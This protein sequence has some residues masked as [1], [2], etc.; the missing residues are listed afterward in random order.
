MFKILKTADASVLK[1]ESDVML[2]KG[3]FEFSKETNDASAPL[4]S[5]LLQLP[6]ITK[7]FISANFIALQK[8][9]AIDWID[10]QEEL[11][12]VIDNY[13][14]QNNGLFNSQKKA[15]VEVYAESTPNPDVMKFVTNKLILKDGDVEFKNA[16]QAKNHPFI[17]SLFGLNFVKSIFVEQY[18]ISLTKDPQTDWQDIIHEIRAHI[19]LNLKPIT[20][21]KTEAVSK[22]VNPEYL[23]AIS[24][25]IIAILDEYIK[26]AVMADG[27]NII[28]ESYNANSKI[29]KVILKGACSGCPSSTVTLKNG[30]ESTL[31]NLLP[32]KIE[33]VE[34]L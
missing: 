1:F 22:T 25:E 12:S 24:Q 11:K 19:K 30:I 21:I 16:T 34:A 2:T 13:F 9:D 18:Y 26:P 10:V 29:V 8:I 5:Q 20:N 32:N 4:V 23:D 14:A 17:A 28:F 3:S 7:V 31:K 33:S 27:G 15:P 6:F